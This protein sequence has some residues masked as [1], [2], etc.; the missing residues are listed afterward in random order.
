MFLSACSTS[1][2][3]QLATDSELYTGKEFSKAYV[4]PKDNPNLPNVLIIGDSISVGYTVAV[5]KLLKGKAD[6]YRVPTNGKHSSY[7]L[8]NIDKWLASRQWHVIHFN[9]G[10]WDICYRNPKSTNQGHR[11][12]V[13]GTL[14]TTPEQYQQNMSAIIAQ[15]KATKAKL[16]WATTTP[17]PKFEVGRIEGDELFYNNIVRDLAIKNGVAI[18]DLHAHALVNIA[19][20]Q[21]SQGDVHFTKNGYHYLAE[22]VA[23]VI[24]FQLSRI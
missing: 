5:R 11:D 4:N 23:K 9:W 13:N 24:R 6:V 7:G 15:L 21:K 22:K 2:H 18:N 10:L 8:N 3:D 14:T 16:I 20:I 1:S 19:D 17:V 12:K